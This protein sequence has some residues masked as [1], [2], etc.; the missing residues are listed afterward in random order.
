MS[1][2]YFTQHHHLQA[3]ESIYLYYEYGSGLWSRYF[4]STFACYI[5]RAIKYNFPDGSS[6]PMMFLL[7]HSMFLM[8][9][10]WNNVEKSKKENRP[11]D[12]I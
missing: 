5:P 12:F 1:K 11:F 3:R 2:G 9:I 4:S 8:Y 7:S 10:S 6:H